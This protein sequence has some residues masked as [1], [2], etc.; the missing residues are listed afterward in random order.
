MCGRFSRHYTWAQLHALYMLTQKV[1][2]SNMQPRYNVCPTTQIDAVVGTVKGREVQSMRWGLIPQWWKRSLKEFKLAT[3]NARVETVA[4][5]PMFRSAFRRNRCLIPAS[6]YYEWHTEGKEKQPYFFTAADGSPI[7]SIAA[8]WDEWT[9]PDSGRAMQS[10][11]M[12]ITEPNQFVGKIH[13]RMPVLL[14]PDQFTPWL[15][16][17][18]GLEILKPQSEDYLKMHPVSKRVNS[19]RTTD[20]DATLIEALTA[21]A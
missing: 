2:H 3:F 13:D 18:A 5:K 21:K 16:G 14:E 4:E 7:L 6:G 15:S 10:C 17:T 1:P 20:E 12:L 8:L 19:S 11:T 9:D